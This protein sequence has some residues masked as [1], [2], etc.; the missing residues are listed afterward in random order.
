LRRFVAEDALPGA[1]LQELVREWASATA[2]VVL[3]VLSDDGA[4]EIRRQLS[5]DRPHAACAAL[6][7]Q[8]VE[9]MPLRPDVRDP[10]ARPYSLPVGFS[11]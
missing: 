1:I 8:A 11:R 6:L 4:E 2:T 7:N 10:L 3:A 9:L 5:A